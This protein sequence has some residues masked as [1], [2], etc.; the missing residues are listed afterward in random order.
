MKMKIIYSNVINKIGKTKLLGFGIPISFWK[1]N[2]KQSVCF[3]CSNSALLRPTCCM[4]ERM[5]EASIVVKTML[6]SRN[7]DSSGHFIQLEVVRKWLQSVHTGCCGRAAG[8]CHYAET[9]LPQ[10]G[11]S[12]ATRGKSEARPSNIKRLNKTDV[13]GKQKSN[14]FKWN[15]TDSVLPSQQSAFSP[16]ASHLGTSLQST[17]RW[18]NQEIHVCSL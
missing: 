15:K 12:C 2:R 18:C 7:A 16:V 1:Q 10:A 11:L 8:W 3:V 9:T 5:S 4:T 17:N 13:T 6:I 14:I